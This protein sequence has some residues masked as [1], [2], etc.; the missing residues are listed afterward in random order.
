MLWFLTHI[1]TT[2]ILCRS[3][4]SEAP[5]NVGLLIRLQGDCETNHIRTGPS[6]RRRQNP[7]DYGYSLIYKS[8]QQRLQICNNQMTLFTLAWFNSY[9]IFRAI[10]GPSSGRLIKYISCHWNIVMWFNITIK[11]IAINNKSNIVKYKGIYIYIYIYIC[12]ANCSIRHKYK[13][14]LPRTAGSISPGVHCCVLSILRRHH[15][16]SLS[17]STSRSGPVIF[18]SFL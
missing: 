2:R 9:Y 8:I 12:L 6:W 15:S 17:S 16:S 1:C 4:T 10:S 5:N 18:P 7:A 11:S 14:L 13:M 3:L